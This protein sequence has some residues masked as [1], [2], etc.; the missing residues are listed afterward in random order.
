M[1]RRAVED[2]VIWHDVEC[3]FY[4][5]DFRLW[6][7]L[8]AEHPGPLLDIGCGTGR[9]ALRLAAAG[10]DVT[11]L[12]SEPSLVAAL[13]ARARERGL[14]VRAGVGDARAF[15]LG[16]SFA[17]VIAPMQVAQ[18]LGGA[19]GRA[20]WL[21]CVHGHLQPGGVLA[22]ALADPFEGIPLEDSMPPLPDVREEDGWVYSSTP[23]VVR[24]DG[25]GTLVERLRQAVSPSGELTESVGVIRLDQVTPGELE[26]EAERLGYRVLP[27]RSVP[28]TD[29]Y[30]GSSVVLL[31][32]V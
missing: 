29:V 11:A 24:P 9:I 13:A 12:D 28:E 27:R 1:S 6:E 20:D 3:A 18:L 10:R 22:A 15:D 32:A 30:V 23:V 21:R 25:D 26:S 17:L 2:A 5:V 4:A 14:R 8:A 31:E 16:R 19:A 7:Q